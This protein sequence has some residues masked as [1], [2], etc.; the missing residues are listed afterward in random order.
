MGE[1]VP[2]KQQRCVVDSFATLEE[3]RDVCGYCL[4]GMHCMFRRGGQ[5]SLAVS[6]SVLSR[7]V[8]DACAELVC[9]LVDRTRRKIIDDF[10]LAER[11]RSE[12]EPV[13]YESGALLTRLQSEWEHDVWDI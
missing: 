10:G 13:L 6:H 2:Q 7:R 5:T 12:S 1:H 4:R 9:G 8:N 3:C 11:A